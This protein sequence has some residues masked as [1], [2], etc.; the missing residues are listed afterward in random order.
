MELSDR[1]LFDRNRVALAAIVSVCLLLTL[2]TGACL[3]SVAGVYEGVLP[4][5]AFSVHI[6]AVEIDAPCP[7]LGVS[8]DTALPFYSVW[9][10]D[11]QPNGTIQFHQ[12]YFVWLK[13][14]WRH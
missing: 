14:S 10:G 7:N 13:H 2:S 6:G 4:A 5:P 11:P 3:L 1:H 12:L 9:R 8:C